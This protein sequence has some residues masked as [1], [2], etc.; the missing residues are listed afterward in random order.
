MPASIP[1]YRLHKPSG[2]AVVTLNGR[3]IYLGRW[4]SPESR[5]AYSR[6]IAEWT[7]HGCRPQTSGA[8]GELT[9]VELIDAYLAFAKTYYSRHGKPSSEYTSL[10]HAL[11][12][13][14]KL[15][16]HVRVDQFGPL[17]LKT[18]RQTW[19]DD[20]LVRRHI[21]HRVNR[22]RRMFKWGVEEELVGSSVLEGLRAVAPLKKGRCAAAESKQVRPVPDA[23]VEA[24]LPFV[25]RQVAAMIQLQRLAGMRPGEVVLLR[26]QDVDRS[27]SI[28]IYS[29]SEHK[30]GYRDHLRE[31]YFGPKA[32]SILA[33]WLDRPED[34]FCFSPLEAEAERNETR[35]RCRRSPMTPS[36]AAR[37]SKANVKRQKRERYDRDS[38][39]RAIEYG[40]HK[41][42]VPHWHPHQ[43]R[44]NCGTQI[45]RDFGLDV[46]QIILGHRSADVTQIYAQVDRQRAFAVVGQTG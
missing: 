41:A 14:H 36:Q 17:A 22:I 12:P 30:T 1:S 13:L 29:P 46:A 37:T 3:D 25:S 21:N 19:V 33:P 20:G 31:V 35:R 39:R 7:L 4:N 6:Q 16:A 34:R 2:Q 11:R 32:Q 27:G 28:W 43:L 40:I 45:R 15:Y 9:V 18:V 23:H 38:Y 24:V 44:H 26:P 42:K 8:R 5:E 10:K